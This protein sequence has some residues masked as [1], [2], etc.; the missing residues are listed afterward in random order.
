M[1]PVDGMK[2]EVVEIRPEEKQILVNLLEL[3]LHD[4][5]EFDGTEL[6]DQGTYG[7]PYI[8]RYWSEPGRHPFF[9]RVDGRLAGFALVR[10]LPGDE[11]DEMHM[12][13]FFIVRKYRRHGVG[14]VAARQIFDRFPGRWVV[15]ERDRNE[16]GQGFW[17]AVIRRYSGD[18]L[19]ERSEDGHVIQEFVV[20]G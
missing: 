5:S 13:E 16:A 3:Y 17:R 7:Y 14:E 19:T 2:V 18:T 12:A 9:I 15:T 6:G 8:D 1:R 20:L 11:A 10:I 4:F